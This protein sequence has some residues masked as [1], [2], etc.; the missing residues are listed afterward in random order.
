ME[1]VLAVGR[2]AARTCPPHLPPTPAPPAP[3]PA[4]AALHSTAR[5]PRGSAPR[6]NIAGGSDS[7]ERVLGTQPR[8]PRSHRHHMGLVKASPTRG[9]GAAR[10]VRAADV[11]RRGPVFTALG[12]SNGDGAVACLALMTIQATSSGLIS[13][14]PSPVTIA[15]P[16]RRGAWSVLAGPE[17][18]AGVFPGRTAPS[19]HALQAPG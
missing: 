1:L 9:R 5:A 7:A 16:G 2:Q 19:S 10:G 11:A 18:P 13:V 14:Q 17:P 8:K 12:G 15:P 4:P 6:A 3:A